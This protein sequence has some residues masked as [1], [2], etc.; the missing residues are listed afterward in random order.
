[1]TI[2]FRFIPHEWVIGVQS[3][4]RIVA[5]VSST[6]GSGELRQRIVYL[7]PLPMCQVELCFHPRL[8]L[9]VHCVNMLVPPAPVQTFANPGLFGPTPGCNCPICTAQKNAQQSPPPSENPGGAT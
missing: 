7:C 4:S 8:R 6:I 1:M 9:P 3:C 5:P 2:R